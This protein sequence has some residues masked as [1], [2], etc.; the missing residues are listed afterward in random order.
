MGEEC[1]SYMMRTQLYNQ[2]YTVAHTIIAH[3]LYVSFNTQFIFLYRSNIVKHGSDSVLAIRGNISVDKTDSSIS[4][5]T[6][7][8]ISFCLIYLTFNRCWG[9]PRATKLRQ[10][11]GG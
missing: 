5:W 6:I 1:F 2:S 8:C 9:T 4:D 3:C 11:N 10:K 7:V